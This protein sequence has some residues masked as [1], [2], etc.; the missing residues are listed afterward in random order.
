MTVIRPNSVSGINSITAQANEIKIFKSD[1]TQGGLM[2]DGAN[3]NATSGISTV[4]ALTVTGNV[5]VGGTLTYQDVTNIDSVGIVTARAGVKV[6][7]NQKVLLGTDNDLEI[8]HDG[9]NARIKNNTGQLW[10]QS[11]NGIRFVDSDVNESFARF[12]DNGAVELYYDGGK[13]LETTSTGVKIDNSSTTDML[14]L[15]VSGTNFA[16]IGHN[17]ASGTN[18]LDVRSEGHMRLLTGGNNER[19]RIT[20]SGAVNIGDSSPNADGSG[21]LNV[22]SSTSGALS[23]FVHSAGNGGLRL[24]G[25]GSGS[26]ANLVFSN[27]YN[28]NSW[29]DEWTIQ[30]HGSDDSLRFL[31]GGVTGTERLRI[32]SAGNVGIGENNPA[33]ILHLKNNAPVITTEATN[34]S[35]GLRVNVLGQTSATSQIFRLQNDNSTL[36]TVLKSGNVGVMDSAPSS[37]LSI[38][39]TNGNAKLQIKRSNTAN[40][41]DDYG[42]ILWRSSGGTAVGGINVARQ[43][44]ENNGYMFFQTANGGSLTERLRISADGGIIK[45]STNSATSSQVIQTFFNKRGSLI[46]KRVHQGANS[47]STTHNLL[48]INSFQS[49]NTRFFAYVTVH[50]VNPIANVG[51]RMETYAAANTGGTRSVGT[52]AVAD[53]GRWGNP[54][55][56]LSLS[57]SGNILRLNTYNNAYMEYSV[58]ITYVAYDGASVTFATN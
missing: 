32:T 29:V 48:T 11:D 20:S 27:D 2:I 46:G 30:M 21:A 33:D 28:N 45:G 39:Q 36:F 54:G 41:T 52:F 13:K 37:L 40:N 1:G 47:S 26:A 4:A 50:Y 38:S 16:K 43:T 24:G 53:G 5:S 55:G 34:A 56:T 19:V 44:A 49:G 8:Y 23:Q 58:D 35:S 42:S 3:L 51:G 10:L 31:S 17:S 15:D 22:Y 6:P 9:S 12:T 25:T 57:W 14:L 18:I 7:D